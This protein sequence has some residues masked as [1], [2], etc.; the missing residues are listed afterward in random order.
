MYKR[1]WA[2]AAAAP[3][4]QAGP[5]NRDD[6]SKQYQVSRIVLLALVLVLPALLWATYV[7]A[8]VMTVG[9]H[10]DTRPADAIV[11]LGTGEYSGW[12][13]HPFGTRLERALFLYE[14]GLAPV[15][16]VAGGDP[17]GDSYTEAAAGVRYLEHQGLPPD[18]LLTVQGNNTYENLL[19]VKVLTKREGLETVLLVSERFH[20]LRSLTMADD[21]DIQ[22]YA[23]PTSTSPID[24]SPASR[25]SATLREVAAYTAYVLGFGNPAPV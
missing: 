8:R 15:V 1:K 20:M 2:G 24:H 23:S 12:P 7:A 22:A 21:L 10:D 13:S 25:F 14:E 18:A 19:E 6:V 16:I 9:E 11:V 3:K 17:E 5:T 4:L